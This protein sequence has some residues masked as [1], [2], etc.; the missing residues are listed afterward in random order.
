MIRLGFGVHAIATV[1]LL[2]PMLACRMVNPAF[3]F[4][5]TEAMAD[6]GT[7]AAEGQD[8][9]SELGD[10]DGDS[11]DGDGDTGPD[12]GDGDGEPTTGDGDGE[13]TTSGDG[14]GESTTGDGDGEGESTTGDGDGD[15]DTGESGDTGESDTGDGDGDPILL[16]MG[17]IDV[18][19][20]I[21][22]A[23]QCQLCAAQHCCMPGAGECFENGS[24]CKCVIDCLDDP[25]NDL[26]ECGAMCSVQPS[27]L[28]NYAAFDGCM[29]FNCDNN[30]N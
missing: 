5:E 19:P 30:C 20:E 28:E 27:A 9:K 22:P 4:R 3:D 8:E 6:D 17:V 10:G 23:D 21:E 7:D 12:T 14:D 15:T 25:M 13:P 24:D 26:M 18:C 29:Q 1:V 11:G 16:D 2:S